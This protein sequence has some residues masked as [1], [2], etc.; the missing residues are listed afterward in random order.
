MKL[1]IIRQKYTPYGGAEKFVSQAL[2]TLSESDNLELLL[3]TRKW[4]D[5]SNAD[6]KN[7]KILDFRN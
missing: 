1:A 5:S 7:K 6:N 2:Q 4:Q 3:F